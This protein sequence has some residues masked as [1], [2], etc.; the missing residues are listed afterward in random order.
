MYF[1]IIDKIKMVCQKIDHHSHKHDPQ[2]IG[3]DPQD[4]LPEMSVVLLFHLSP[5][6]HQGVDAPD[7][8]EYPHEEGVDDQKHESFTISESDAVAEPWTVMVHH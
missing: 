5:D 8:P 4:E 2:D 7:D 1:V 6:D 3:D